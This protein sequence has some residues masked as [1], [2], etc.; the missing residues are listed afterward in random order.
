[1]GIVRYSQWD[2]SQDPLGDDFA[3]DDVVS[4]LTE[5][6]LDGWDVDAAMQRL[7]LEGIEGRFD[8]LRSLADRIRQLRDLPGRPDPLA[9]MGERLEHIKNLEMEALAAEAGDDARF[10]ELAL[11][12]LDG[13]TISQIRGLREWDWRSGEAEAEFEALLAELRRMALDTAF[14]DMTEQISSLSQP[15]IED[16]KNMLSDLNGLLEKANDGSGPTQAE[17]EEFMERHG[18]HFPEDPETFEKLMEAIARRQVAMSR[19]V[20][21]LDEDQRSELAGLLNDL[22]DDMDLSFEM[23]RLGDNL[24]RAAPTMPWGR[25]IEMSDDG[26]DLRSGLDGIDRVSALE[27]LERSLLQD[28][29][30]ASLEDVDT[31]ALSAELGEE[32]GRSLE[33]L[34]AIET[35]LK[36]AGVVSRSKGRLQLTPRGV[37]KLGERALTKVFERVTGDRVGIHETPDGGGSDELTGSSRPWRFGDSFRLDLRK[38][39]Q[40]SVLR[41]VSEGRSDRGLSLHPDD[42]EI[43]EAERRTTVATVLLLD[44]SRSMPLRGHWQGAKRMALALHTLITTAFPEDRLSIVGF[45]DYARVLTPADLADVD[46]EPVYGTNMEHA[47]AL[48]GRILAK[49]GEVSK[50]VL[51]VT[52]GEPT[53]HLVGS[54]VFFHWPPVPETLERTYR[55]ARRLSRSGVTMNVF[56]LEQSPGLAAFVDRLA[57]I[58]EGRVFSATGGELGD[59]VVTDYVRGR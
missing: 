4:R 30:G 20:A 13:G 53:A 17:F 21:S 3:V 11:D 46:W 27:D 54:H 36:N 58:V 39:L 29:P 41:N 28:Y 31:G 33:Q 45:S 16:L 56:M 57:R 10:A 6:I 23:A 48:A 22:M 34:K 38:T 40:N 26:I 8:G 44:M 19:Y 25:A 15:E 55:E 47:F 24:R 49:E 43:A 9:G 32:A 5:D 18:H 1:M 50:Q 2:G 51:L 14:N 35:M 59:L 42:F 37:R 12:A 52:D 7:I